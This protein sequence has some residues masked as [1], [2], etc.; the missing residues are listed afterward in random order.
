MLY[1]TSARVSFEA[2][3]HVVGHSECA[4]MGHGH[5]WAIIV[6][7]TGGLDPK[8]M[9]VV[10]HGDLLS[11]LRSVVDEVAGRNLNDMLPGVTTTPEGIATYMKERL[12]LDWPK[13]SSIVVEMGPNISVTLINELR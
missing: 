3:H 9:Q 2:G 8:T 1:Q 7:V 11:A 10:D 5:R 12:V 13:I 4:V 6:A